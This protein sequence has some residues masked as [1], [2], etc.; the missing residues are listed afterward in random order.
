MG[1]VKM[2]L[3]VHRRIIDEL[4]ISNLPVV[5]VKERNITYINKNS[6]RYKM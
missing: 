6:E 1:R 4:T 3:G 2:D 5:S